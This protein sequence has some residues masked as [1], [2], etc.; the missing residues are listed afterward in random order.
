MVLNG[1]SEIVRRLKEPLN[2]DVIQRAVRNEERLRFHCATLSD[3]RGV[4]GSL[5]MFKQYVRGILQSEEKQT[6][7]ESFL[8][9]PIATNAFVENVFTE[10]NKVFYGQN[11]VNKVTFADVET[12]RD[13]DEYSHDVLRLHENFEE[14][15]LNAMATMIN[16]LI[17]VDL[18]REQKGERPSPYFYFLPIQSV[19]TFDVEADSDVL[20]Y[21]MFKDGDG[22]LVA[23][24]DEYYR[25]FSFGDKGY[26]D[27]DSMTMEVESRHGLGFVPVSFFWK[28]Y[29]HEDGRC[30]KRSPIAKDLDKLD[31]LLFK[32]ISQQIAELGAEYPITWAFEEDKG[33]DY[34]TEDGIVCDQGRLRD[35]NGMYVLN[36]DGSVMD[37]PVCGSR[38][39][40]GAGTHIH[41]PVPGPDQP[42]MSH[43]VG[44]LVTPTDTLKRIAESVQEK[45]REIFND[46]VGKDGFF[47]ENSMSD[48]QIR[49]NFENRKTVLTRL[50]VNFERAEEFIIRTVCALRYS[51]GQFLGCTIDYGTEFYLYSV[52]ELRNR[53]KKAKDAG[54]SESELSYID[55]QIVA[56]ELRNNP[57]QM[58]RAVLLRQIEPYRNMTVHELQ[59]LAGS[60]VVDGVLFAVKVN[61]PSLIDR[62]ER[63]NGNIIDFGSAVTLSKK[64]GIILDTLKRY[65]EESGKIVLAKGAPA[66]ASEPKDKDGEGDE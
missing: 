32:K 45:E 39:F 41:I 35:G 8:R 12:E 58:R 16:S 66:A 64:V 57:E 23:I 19:E 11:F 52:E 63:E 37:C 3:S 6:L 51:E 17:V 62:F 18:P 27:W 24:D 50:K 22:N 49:S 44:M 4:W 55:E 46:I 36:T 53:Y 9:F 30:V 13:W 48:M 38:T 10:L 43:P 56:T 21:V 31:Y 20:E 65:V 26:G 42:D 60:G 7:F 29:Y 25:V 15:S 1:K 54:A 61:F 14:K 47:S 40:R 5:D 33:C 2:K 34:S 59:T 28:D